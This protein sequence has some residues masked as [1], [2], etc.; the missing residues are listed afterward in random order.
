MDLSFASHRLYERMYARVRLSSVD[1]PP[2]WSIDQLDAE[3][4]HGQLELLA[5]TDSS[6]H[7]RM[8][9]STMSARRLFDTLLVS[10]KHYSLVAAFLDFIRNNDLDE[11][12]C[13]DDGSD[14]DHATTYTPIDLNIPTG[15]CQC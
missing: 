13:S 14:S 8:V 4:W 1:I 3:A 6:A 11:D 9:F 10:P 7:V 12:E 5:S 2:V 15:P